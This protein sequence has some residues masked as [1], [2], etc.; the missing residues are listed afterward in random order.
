M[1]GSQEKRE[2][3]TGRRQEER[4]QEEREQE[5]REQEEREKEAGGEGVRGKRREYLCRW[6]GGGGGGV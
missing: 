1:A 5:E 4:E 2:H 3:E 6:R